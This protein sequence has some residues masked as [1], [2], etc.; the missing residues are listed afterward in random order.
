MA[1]IITSSPSKALPITNLV[2]RILS[3]VF[4]LGSAIVLGGNSLKIS[5]DSIVITAS[6]KTIHAYK[7]GVVLSAFGILYGFL[8]LPFSIYQ[9]CTAKDLIGFL[10]FTVYADKVMSYVL[11]TGVRRYMVSQSIQRSSSTAS[12][13]SSYR[14]EVQ[15]STTFAPSTTLSQKGRVLAQLCFSLDSYVLQY[16]Q[17]SHRYI[18]PRKSL[19]RQPRQC[20]RRYRMQK[21]NVKR[22]SDMSLN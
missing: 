4:L 1:S 21:S 19:R 7:F 3:L 20:H 18:S 22:T 16:L 9:L 15:T 17:F 11:I 5:L 10:H 2:F 13:M 6:A 8:Q 12:T 14:V